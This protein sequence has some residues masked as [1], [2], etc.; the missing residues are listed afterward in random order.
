V[1][2]VFR[3][4]QD[5]RVHFTADIFDSEGVRLADDVPIPVPEG[6]DGAHLMPVNL[7]DGRA[8]VIF[9]EMTFSPGGPPSITQQLLLEL[10]LETAP[11]A[12]AAALRFE[13]RDS[14]K[15]EAVTT[16]R[17]TLRHGKTTVEKTLASV[18]GRYAVPLPEQPGDLRLTLLSN[19]FAAVAFTLPNQE[20][21]LGTIY[22]D[23]GVTVEG[24]LRQET[25]GEPLVGA[26]VRAVRRHPWGTLAAARLGHVNAAGTDAEGYFRLGG[27][28]AGSLCLTITHPDI[29]PS[30]LALADAEESRRHDLG[31]VLLGGGVP[32]EG[33]VV[34]GEGEPRAGVPVDLRSG[35]WRNPCSRLRTVTGEDGRFHFPQVGPGSYRIAVFQ[36]QTLAAVEPVQVETTPVSVGDLALREQRIEGQVRLAGAPAPG[37]TLT[38]EVWGHQGF[39]PPPV[40]FTTAGGGQEL[41]SDLAPRLAAVVEA[42]RFSAR[43]FLPPGEA[44]ATYQPDASGPRYRLPVVIEET[45]GTVSIDLEFDGEPLSGIVLGP[46]GTPLGGAAVWLKKAE[47]AIRSTV[48]DGEGRFTL[49]LVPPGRYF[50]EGQLEALE[51]ELSV[52]TGATEYRLPLTPRRPLR[53]EILVST[54]DGKPAPGTVVALRDG[55]RTQLFQTTGADGRATF[56]GLV[57][58]RYHP[59]LLHAGGLIPTS[60]IDLARG[61]ATLQVPLTLPAVHPV[62]LRAEAATLD[63]PRLTSASGVSVEPLLAYLG[64]RLQFTPDGYLELPPLAAGHWILEMPRR[65][66]RFHF[67]VKARGGVV[68]LP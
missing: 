14:L 31:T 25:T 11:G 33:R 9:R 19:G 24:T 20:A 47:V 46:R 30:P 63:P 21:D 62:T 60:P 67:E 3:H 65:G 29:A 64:R 40:F 37:G 15:G 51:G 34:G 12:P 48:A 61:D 41:I 8:L 68:E 57:P 56:L 59:T 39:D 45:A 13:L 35:P 43:G 7:P 23:P 5:G 66:Q 54:R 18:D 17:A 1:A 26:Q 52:S 2:L 4:A 58:G 55:D 32:L 6:G 53:L 36:G 44:I 10:K 50:L 22:L 16:A 27:L 38:L 49:P 42:G 28:E